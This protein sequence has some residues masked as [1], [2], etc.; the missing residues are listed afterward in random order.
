MK[1]YFGWFVAI[2]VLTANVSAQKGYRYSTVPGTDNTYSI[3][4]KEIKAIPYAATKTLAPTME[5]TT[6]DFAQL[7]G[8]LTLSVTVTPC[9]TADKMT[10]I[11]HADGTNRVVTFSAGFSA[12]GT[13]TVPASSYTS[14]TFVFDGV[15]W[16]EVTRQNLV[17]GSVTTLLAGNGTAGS[18]SISFTSDTD[19]GLYRI[20]ANNVGVATNGAKVLDISNT[21]LGVTGTLTATGLVSPAAA[22][23][24]SAGTVGAPAYSYTGQTN[25]G[26]YKISS[27]QEGQ[28]IGG[29][30]VGGWNASGL[31]TNAITEQT[32]G[33]GITLSKAIIQQN[34]ATAI[35]TTA[36][37]T[38]AQ[39]AGG[40]L[41]STSAAAVTMTLP[42][43]SLMATQIGAT[44]GTV[45]EFVVDNSAGANTVTVA[46]GSG[47]VA[48][49]FPGTNTLT[50]PAD[51]NIGTAG[52]RL[53]FIS[54][55]KATLTRIN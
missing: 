38:A 46:V 11:F 24:N 12:A 21:G 26:S 45:F 31:F 54:A 39:L 23:N 43:A 48:S 36:T 19:I 44:Q 28:A 32:S 30:L 2:C 29:A 14:I 7:T 22:I 41:T 25:M 9:Y 1:K 34:T 53:T 37:V 13:L 15:A 3:P 16:F 49:G 47:I 6:Y 42:T 18:P 40:L 17:S 50:V 33:S 10:C 27:T 52:F 35:N 4:H 20:G 51:A 55:S 5:E 8:A